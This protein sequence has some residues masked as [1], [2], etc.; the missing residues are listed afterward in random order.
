MPIEYPKKFEVCPNCGS[1]VRVVESEAK[2]EA[3]KGNIR[4]STKMACM[5]TQNAI[6]DPMRAGIIAPKEV[7]IIMA[8][9][10]I[11]AD[12]GTLYCV[13]VQKAVGRADPHTRRDNFEQF[14]P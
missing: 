14:P 7:P 5:I 1:M 11:C 8:R 3:S 4:V 13:E 10:D 6:F 2:E 9:Y 12:C